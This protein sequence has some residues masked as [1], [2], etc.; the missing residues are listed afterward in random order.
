M[1][2]NITIFLISLFSYGTILLFLKYKFVLLAHY[3]ET[4]TF[5]VYEEEHNV[6]MPDG[7]GTGS[8]GSTGGDYT[9]HVEPNQ[10]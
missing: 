9:R 1:E 6:S 3:L 4:N 5:K 10:K 2:I 8:T 7:N